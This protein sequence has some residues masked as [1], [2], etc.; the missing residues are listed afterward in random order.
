MTAPLSAATSK[1]F[2]VPL[3]AFAVATTC[4]PKAVFK[5]PLSA[6]ATPDSPH[7]VVP[8]SVDVAVKKA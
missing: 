7:A 3:C 6:N 1:S 8:V 4:V 5:S 2:D